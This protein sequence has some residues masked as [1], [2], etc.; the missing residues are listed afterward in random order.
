[1]PKPVTDPNLI[2]RLEAEAQ[3]QQ[4]SPRGNAR[5]VTDP[6]LIERLNA[7]A[8]QQQGGETSGGGFLDTVGDTLSGA[9]ETVGD[10][11]TGVYEIAKGRQDPRFADVP[12]FTGEAVPPEIH[13]RYMNAMFSSASVD[14]EVWGDVVKNAL[15][16]RLIDS[17]RDSHGYEIITYRGDDGQEYTRYLNK[18]GLDWVDVQRFGMGSLPYMATGA[19]AGR[20]TRTSPL[21]TRMAVQGGTAAATSIGSDILA[22]ERYGS[23]ENPSLAR[24]G[25][26][27]MGGAVGEAAGAMLGNIA[28][29]YRQR[30]MTP[31]EQ[32][33][34]RAENPGE[35]AA[36]IK[37]GEFDIPT[38]AGQRT[39]DPQQLLLEDEMRRSLHGRPARD[40]MTEFDLRQKRRIA[41]GAKQVRESIAPGSAETGREA[42]ERT[43]QA[44]R[45]A[46]EASR[47][48][49]SA[50]WR[51]VP[52]VA[53][54]DEAMP[55]LAG[56]I[57]KRIDDLGFGPDERL[58][59]AAHR[60]MS[61]LQDYVQGKP[62][63]QA[64]DL[65]GERGSRPTLDEMRRRLLSF[66][67]SADSPQDQAVANAIYAGF[68]DWIDD[69][70]QSGMIRGV[71]RE[72]IEELN[73]AD[74]GTL[75]NGAPDQQLN[76]AA[77]LEAARRFTREQRQLFEPQG[78]KDAAGKLL[79]K[80]H[81]N[82]D[83]PERLVADLFGSP[84]SKPKPGA[85]EAM[86]RLKR[87]LSERNSEALNQIKAAYWHNLVRGRN[88]EMLSPG[89]LVAK[90]K[91][92]GSNQASL[93]NELFSRQE[94]SLIRRYMN[95]VDTTTYVPP[96]P[97]GTSFARESQRQRCQGNFMAYL[98]RRRAQGETF[99]GNPG[100]ST[101]FHFLARKLPFDVLNTADKTGRTL[102]ETATGQAV[103]MRKPYST[104][105]RGLAPQ[106]GAA[107]AERETQR[108]AP[109]QPTNPLLVD[110][111]TG[112]RR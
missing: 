71:S 110:P 41:S 56:N 85:V 48:E 102:A 34:A 9:A 43:S 13:D 7:K 55:R 16:D 66:V 6:Q 3:R 82:A 69:I 39:K 4:R 1:M 94:R 77:K 107:R 53:P 44:L 108:P 38:T 65:L 70:A 84:G 47:A 50:L 106:T 30:G 49:E 89:R 42:A 112:T 79:Q 52:E 75:A 62:V 80:I 76:V 100:L 17:K 96:N 103:R 26:A 90:I 60:Q 5:E 98:L 63:Q 104:V 32:T 91:E 59:P 72:A 92:A 51:Q 74:I 28:R 29:R 19:V 20:F 64:Y 111:L 22:R 2:Q 68:N 8:R 109:W 58:T 67:R 18:P 86:R 11:A 25:G 95:A 40:V 81:D 27:A 83:T 54:A 10:F 61:L 23:D 45:S 73:P 33:I 31:E 15:G 99:R 12:K 78:P 35:A 101:F 105:T 37:T 57:R 46:R 93:I 36:A 21:L 24:A 97:S 87:I 14:D 88:G